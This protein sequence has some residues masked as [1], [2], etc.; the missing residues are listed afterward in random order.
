MCGPARHTWSSN[1]LLLWAAALSV[2]LQ[3]GVVHLPPLNDAF[4]TTPLSAADWVACVALASAV[5]WVA[6]I[7][8]WLL[9]RTQGS[10]YSR[11]TK[12]PA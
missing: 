6:E 9:R 8:K 3:I 4:A 10:D 11:N 7:R 1:R 12:N 2:V 5:L